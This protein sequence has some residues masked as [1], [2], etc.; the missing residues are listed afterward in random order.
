L[1]ILKGKVKE[2]LTSF[3]HRKKKKE[4][5]SAEDQKVKEEDE[6]FGLGD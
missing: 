2:T 1:E 4:R 6:Y 3:R 5:G